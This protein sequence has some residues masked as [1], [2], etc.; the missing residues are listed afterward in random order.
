[1]RIT[2]K[3][4]FTMILAFSATAGIAVFAGGALAMEKTMDLESAR[5]KINY[6][7]GVSVIRN[8]KQ[9]G[10]D[11]DMDM[12]I[13]GMKD[14]YAGTNLLMDDGE[15][16]SVL[17]SV[18]NDIRQKQRQARRLSAADNR[19]DGEAFLREN[20]KKAGVITLP[21]GLQYKIERHGDGKKPADNDTVVCNYR[22]SLINGAEIDNT[23]IGGKPAVFRV[24]DGV[25]PG[26]REAIKLMPVGSRWTVYIPPHLAYGRE[27]S[28]MIIGPDET[29]V[30]EVELI[31]IR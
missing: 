18:Q 3:S 22:S 25:I 14:A 27:G 5:D 1:M 30:F 19:A 13:R 16:R 23:F 6:S 26:W 21:S 2:L 8:F 31:A 15:I 17:M 24:R 11:L 28:G 7:I 9:Q 20:S 29:I 4:L 10:V 12:V